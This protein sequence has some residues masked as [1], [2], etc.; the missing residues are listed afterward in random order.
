MF[1]NT[2]KNRPISDDVQA[3]NRNLKQKRRKI[4]KA[5]QFFPKKWLNFREMAIF[6]K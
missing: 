6:C 4:E 2:K 1:K 3:E 5:A